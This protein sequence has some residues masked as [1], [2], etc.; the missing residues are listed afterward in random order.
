MA[1]IKGL[2][3]LAFCAAIGFTFLLLSCA[4]P[5]FGVWWP[6]FAIVFYILS[7][8]PTV[9]SGRYNAANDFSSGVSVCSDVA[10][11]L[12]AAIIVSAYGFPIVLATVPV[13]F[14]T[15]SIIHWGA[16]ILV[17]TANTVIFG[18]IYAYFLLFTN[19]NEDAW[20]PAW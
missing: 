18:T 4:L 20:M 5:F 16:A 12:T 2:I 8:I 6:M 7:P 10:T 3:A 11:F 19:P 17:T 13:P 1:G 14:T 9:I 15:D